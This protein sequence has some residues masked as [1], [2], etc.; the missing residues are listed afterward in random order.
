MLAS[1]FSAGRLRA[2]AVR[3]MVQMGVDVRPPR[4]S[5]AELVGTARRQSAQ[6]ARTARSR[7]SRSRSIPS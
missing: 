2:P 1:Q 6:A 5:A 7:N 4:L 3:V